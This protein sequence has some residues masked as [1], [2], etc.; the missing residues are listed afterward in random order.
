MY[1][2][3]LRGGF[4]YACVVWCGRLLSSDVTLNVVLFLL[5]IY[6]VIHILYIYDFICVYM[7]VYRVAIYTERTFTNRAAEN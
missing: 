4:V 7:Y 6:R 2:L 1:V 3:W 5:E